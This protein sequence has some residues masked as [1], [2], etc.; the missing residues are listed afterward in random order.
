[1]F[2]KINSKNLGKALD[3]GKSHFNKGKKF[4]LQKYRNS[5]ERIFL[6]KRS[7]CGNI[8]RQ[9]TIGRQEDSWQAA[10]RQ[11]AGRQQAGRQ[12]AG[13]HAGSRQAA[14]RQATDRQQTGS[15]QAA[16]RQQEHR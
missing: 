4:N 9:Q 12:A 10:G 8:L 6:N 11:Q 3:Q 13:R 15:R 5:K 16:G 14:G 2:S 7:N 1:M